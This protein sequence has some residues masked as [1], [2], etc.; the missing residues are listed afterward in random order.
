MVVSLGLNKDFILQNLKHINA[1]QNTYFV[2]LSDKDAIVDG[3]LLTEHIVAVN[4]RGCG[5]KSSQTLTL[6]ALNTPACSYCGMS[7]EAGELSKMR[8][9]ILNKEENTVVTKS[10][11]SV[12]IFIALL[13]FFWPGALIYL[14]IKKSGSTKQVVQKMQEFQAQAKNQ[15]SAS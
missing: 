8:H 6:A 1:Q 7:I 3:R 2:Y 15:M 10:G 11:F 5:S 9:E 12:P 13:I 14:A 4:C